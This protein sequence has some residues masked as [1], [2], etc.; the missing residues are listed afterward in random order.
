MTN[1]EEK[2]VNLGGGWPGDAG[3]RGTDKGD[4]ASPKLSQGAALSREHL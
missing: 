4:E 2:W 1:G 3:G